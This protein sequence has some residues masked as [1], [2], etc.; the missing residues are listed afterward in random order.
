MLQLLDA[1]KSLNE[2]YRDLHMSK[3]TV[4]NYKQ[5]AGSSGIPL[6]KLRRLDDVQLNQ[7]LQPPSA[8]PQPDERKEELDKELEHYL[9]ELKK[10]YVSILLLW[11]EHPNGYQ[12]TQFKKYLKEYKKR[13]E[14]SYYNVYV[15]GEEM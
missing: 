9:T 5:R 8:V 1:G 15:P 7:L 14:F 12:Y 2:I 11:E 6:S 13:K 4:H 10:S 3:R